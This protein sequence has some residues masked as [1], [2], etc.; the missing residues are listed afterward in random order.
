[1]RF[2]TVGPLAHRAGADFGRFGLGMKTASLSQGTS[3]T[4]IS[5]TRRTHAHF[6]RWD[7]EHVRRVVEWQLLNELTPVGKKYLAQLS[8]SRSS[9]VVLIES[10]DRASFTNLPAP[11]VP[12]ALADSLESVR[13]HLGMVFHRFTAEDS[14]E[15]RL[16]ETAVQ[17]WDPF[18]T[19][20]SARLPPETLRLGS[21][22]IRVAPYA[23][24]HHSRL[25]DEQHR[26]AGGAL[27]GTN[28]RGFLS[29]GRGDS[30]C[31]A[32]S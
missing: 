24:P 29:T 26:A 12:G 21:G 28:T 13:R 19:G 5:K 15:I 6:R 14:V 4:V 18:L 8:A 22:E 20:L 11:Q 17:P 3:L 30:S 27:A 1:M 25:T 16:G 10:L 7:L 9:T 2:G 32:T 31:S 23:L